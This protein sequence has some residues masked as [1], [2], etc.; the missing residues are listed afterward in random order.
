MENKKRITDAYGNEVP[1]DI[2][3]DEYWAKEDRMTDMSYKESVRAKEY[4]ERWHAD[5]TQ[6]GVKVCAICG[7]EECICE[8][9]DEAKVCGNHTQSKLKDGECCQTK[10][11]KK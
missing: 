10:I 1:S 4:R 2:S 3:F 9:F 6:I 5:T 11:E 7:N 8:Y